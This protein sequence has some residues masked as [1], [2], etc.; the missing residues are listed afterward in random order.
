MVEQIYFDCDSC[1][2]ELPEDGFIPAWSEV[3]Q[4]VKNICIDCERSAFLSLI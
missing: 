3:D 4:V 2:I 1:G